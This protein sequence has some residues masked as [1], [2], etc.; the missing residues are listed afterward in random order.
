MFQMLN[1][2]VFALAAWVQPIPVDDRVGPEL[3]QNT[4]QVKKKKDN[5]EKIDKASEPQHLIDEDIL[6]SG[7]QHQ[8]KSIKSRSNERGSQKKTEQGFFSGWSGWFMALFVVIVFIVL[9]RLFL[10]KFPSLKGKF[11]NGQLMEVLGRSQLDRT[12]SVCMLKVGNRVLVLGLAEGH[13]QTLSEI[14]DPEEMEGIL[15]NTKD[16]FIDSPLKQFKGVFKDI[17]NR[18]KTV[19]SDGIFVEE[20]NDDAY[21]RD[22]IQKEL[23]ALKERIRGVQEQ[24]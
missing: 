5:T 2:L 6:I 7:S 1:I 10:N 14:T 16:L 23:S 19:S 3:E 20:E 9:L 4:E 11:L 17:T 24:S 18:K 12:H 21:V 8:S 22:R 15:A 13:T